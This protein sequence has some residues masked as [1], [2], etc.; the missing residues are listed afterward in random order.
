MNQPSYKQCLGSAYPCKTKL[1]L[2]LEITWQEA[3][4]GN[5]R[6]PGLVQDLES[7]KCSKS[8][9]KS[10]VSVSIRN[11]ADS[12]QIICPTSKGSFAYKVSN[13]E[14]SMH[15]ETHISYHDSHSEGTK[16]QTRLFQL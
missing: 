10:D 12:G 1:K 3:S 13:Q 5:T 14:G 9:L 8:N 7:T 4:L 2:E 15:T 11:Y 6:V 16:P